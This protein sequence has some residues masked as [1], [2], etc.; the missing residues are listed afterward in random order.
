MI[1]IQKKKKD[2]KKQQKILF[3]Q[4]YWNFQLKKENQKHSLFAFGFVGRNQIII[5]KKSL[6]KFEYDEFSL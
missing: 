5:K 1:E 2:S 6:I 4:I 3:F